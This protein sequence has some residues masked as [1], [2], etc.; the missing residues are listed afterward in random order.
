MNGSVV[1]D[2]ADC[3]RLHGAASQ[4]TSGFVTVFSYVLI[5]PIKV[6]NHL[7]SIKHMQLFNL[8]KV[9]QSIYKLECYML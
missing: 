5:Y 8:V 6:K 3:N 9:I 4:K 2:S 1:G 7:F